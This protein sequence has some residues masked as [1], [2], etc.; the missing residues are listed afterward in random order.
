MHCCWV[1]HRRNRPAT[2]WVAVDAVAA[3]AADEMVGAVVVTA[4]AVLALPNGRDGPKTGLPQ[5]STPCGP[6]WRVV[7]PAFSGPYALPARK[8]SAF[9]FAACRAHTTKRSSALPPR[10]YPRS[11]SMPGSSSLVVAV[12]V[13]DEVAVDVCDEVAVV[14][15]LSQP[16]GQWS[17][18]RT[19]PNVLLQPRRGISTVLQCGS[20]YS[21]S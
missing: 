9:S 15:Q 10:K 18:I 13:A 6:D 2:R 17:A 16:S 7:F 4:A 21:P 1:F 3:A 19:V 14:T 11:H 20:S 12:D 8:S 5:V